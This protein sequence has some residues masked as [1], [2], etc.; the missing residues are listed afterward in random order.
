M[1][2]KGTVK[3][4]IRPR[5]NAQTVGSEGRQS[6]AQRSGLPTPSGRGRPQADAQREPVRVTGSAGDS[7]PQTS[8]AG[9]AL[10]LLSVPRNIGK[11]LDCCVKHEA[12]YK[13]E[14]ERRAPG[15]TRAAR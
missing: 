12:A 7:S 9:K 14:R 13:L 8:T 6:E 2:A 3:E 4:R 1:S 10:I 15:R 5:R 11:P